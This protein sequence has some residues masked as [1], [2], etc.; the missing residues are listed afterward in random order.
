[1]A[2]RAI[3]PR[4]HIVGAST[5][6]DAT[7]DQVACARM[8]TGRVQAPRGLRVRHVSTGLLHG[9]RETS[10]EASPVVSGTSEAGRLSR[11]PTSSTRGVVHGHSTGEAGELGVTP[12]VPVEERNRG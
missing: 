7:E 2:G 12:G 3:E 9:N 8:R 5:S 11:K 4:K 1:L 6:S 10:G